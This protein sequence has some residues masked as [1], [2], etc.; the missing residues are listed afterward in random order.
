MARMY[1]YYYVCD[2]CGALI[3]SS[4]TAPHF[5]SNCIFTQTVD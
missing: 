1:V 5:K 2:H 4:A 3:S